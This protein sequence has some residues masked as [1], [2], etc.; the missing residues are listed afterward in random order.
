MQNFTTELTR[1]DADHYRLIISTD[2]KDAVASDGILRFQFALSKIDVTWQATI[3]MGAVWLPLP[4]FNKSYAVYQLVKQL[5]Q[6][7]DQMINPCIPNL[8]APIFSR[9]SG[10]WFEVCGWY[11]KCHVYIARAPYEKTW[12]AQVQVDPFIVRS[13]GEDLPVMAAVVM[14][15]INELEEKIGKV[16][17]K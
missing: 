3:P 4:T 17:A 2:C 13:D 6:L 16:F 1:T 8:D 10:G 5:A 9:N 14:H 7:I 15:K 12:H 11:H